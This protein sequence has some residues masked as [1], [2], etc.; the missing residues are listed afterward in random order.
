MPQRILVLELVCSNTRLEC[1]VSAELTL[2]E[3]LEGL[4]ELCDESVQNQFDLS[5]PTVLCDAQSHRILDQTKTV[6][7]L[8]L[9]DGFRILI[10]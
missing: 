7:Q 3:M 5:Q 1:E 2:K 6:S 10:Y 4:Y 9:N 8:G